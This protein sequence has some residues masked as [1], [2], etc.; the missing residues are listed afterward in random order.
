MDGRES[1]QYERWKE[2]AYRLRGENRHLL[3]ELG[4]YR[5]AWYRASQRIDQLERRVAELTAENKRLKQQVEELT[6]AARQTPGAAEDQFAAKPS[7]VRRK[8]KRPGRKKGHPAALR[9][10][11]LESEDDHRRHV[12]MVWP[13]LDGPR[14]FM[15][16]PKRPWP[17]YGLMELPVGQRVYICQSESAAAEA[18]QA[19]AGGGVGGA[20]AN[21]VEKT[22]FSPLS[23]R[24]VVILPNNDDAGRDLGSA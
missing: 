5:P 19:G 3:R 12:R 2:E 18:R 23:G 9:P 8:R 16:E 4:T 20:R 11:E 17:L 13:E 1:K 14:W 24:D 15:G 22:D 6:L 10:L 7:V 21:G